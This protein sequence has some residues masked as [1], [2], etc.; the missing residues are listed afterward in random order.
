MSEKW[1]REEGG[2]EGSAG[3]PRLL[4]EPSVC[5]ADNRHEP[6]EQNEGSPCAGLWSD[7]Y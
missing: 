5:Q 4:Q 2:R 6:E 1:E 3:N 7:R